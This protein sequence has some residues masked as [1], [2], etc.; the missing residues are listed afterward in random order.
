LGIST[1]L[2]KV[3]AADRQK[4]VARCGSGFKNFYRKPETAN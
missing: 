4:A 3:V 2:G 1:R